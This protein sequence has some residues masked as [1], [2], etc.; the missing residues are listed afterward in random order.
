MWKEKPITGYGLKSFRFQCWNVMYTSNDAN[1][2]CSTHP[3]NYYM[4]ILAETGIIGLVLLILFFIFILKNNY[5]YIKEYNIKPS[6]ELNFILPI[7]LVIFIEL[8]PLKS[9]G[10]FFTTWN[11]TFFWLTISLLNALKKVK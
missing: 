4:E 10:S 3:H 7:I 6:K 8:W 11:A 1:L 9:T 2:R 5:K